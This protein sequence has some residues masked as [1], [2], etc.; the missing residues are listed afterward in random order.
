RGAAP[1]APP[2]VRVVSRRKVHGLP[3]SHEKPPRPLAFQ[4]ALLLATELRRMRLQA[5]TRRPEGMLHV[6]HFVVQDIFH[7]KRR[8]LGA[9]QA[10]IDEDLIEARVEAA[11]LRA[12]RSRAPAQERPVQSP[13]KILPIQSG[14][15][16]RK[17]MEFPAL[18][19]RATPRSLA[20][21]PQHAAACAP[22]ES[23]A[24]R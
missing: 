14:K 4:E 5:A 18:S 21:H 9:V 8:Q 6:Q 1:V 22:R 11:E 19:C 24:W 7:H 16:A 2:P 20:A 17:I 3:E 15:Q 12:P 10:R 13:G 23:A